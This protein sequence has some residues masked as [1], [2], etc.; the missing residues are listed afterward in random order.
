MSDIDRSIDGVAKTIAEVLE[1]K[2]Y[3]IDY[4][5]REY[6]WESKQM[7]ELV[8]DLTTK[9]L[10]LYEPDH[11]RRDVA[12]YRGYYLGSI[13]VSQKGSQPFIVDGQQ[14]LTSLTL[15]LTYLRRLQQNREDM[16]DID[17]LIFS[18]KFGEKSFNLDVPDRK[19]CM[20]SLFEHGEHEPPLDA[21]ESV[22]T[23]VGRYTE[24]DGLFPEELKS[25]ALPFFID[26]LKDRVQLV[27]ITAYTDDDAYAIFETMN[28]RGLKLTP[29]DMLKGYLLANMEDGEPRTKAND[30]W[31]KR[32]RALNERADDAGSDFLK[33]WLRSQYST[34]IRER[35]KG[36][37]PEDWDRIG[38]EFHRWLRG[39]HERI[40]LNSR[41]DFY[42]FVTRDF[43]FYSHQYERILEAS[44]GTFPPDSPL[45][46]IRYNADLGF[47]LQ[48]QLLLAP[49]RVE[50]SQQTI[51]QKLEIVGRF[52]DILLAWRIWNFRA[53]AY[54]TM[55]YAMFNVMRD[56]RSL[57]IDELAKALRDYLHK[58]DETFDSN[59]DLYV[60][61]QNRGQLHKILARITD[62][63]TVNSG[64]AS[65]YIELT[66][67]TKVKHEVEHIWADRYE[68]HTNEFSH[69]ADFARHRNRIGNLLLLP[70]QF[71]ASYHDDPYEQKLPHYYGQ[72]ILAASLNALSYQKNPGFA[73]FIKSSGLPFRPYE[74][75]K[76]ANVIERGNLY[77]EIAKKVWNPDDLLAVAKGND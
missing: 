43:D 32:L 37:R 30:L 77:R 59:D 54:S 3:S 64:Q 49:L 21:P 20:E 26:W 67:G 18:E 28:D 27:Q 60:H 61:Q 24:L 36:A 55:Q 56:I 45:R 7:A 58:I 31:R 34:K 70:K 25:R 63:I 11:A 62:Y 13:I 42:Q 39:A 66:N 71:N 14:R 53:T 47:T 6:K 4:Y 65:L 33:T 46:Y 74:E 19:D 16:V 68:R 40:G 69:E 50:D 29:S 41:T 12:K 22:H 23:L 15:L 51:E 76:A 2:K 35:R 57:G 48:D 17:Q 38:T 52:T 5:Q 72:N 44:S 75:F 9:F 73:S 10:E 1:K 8:A